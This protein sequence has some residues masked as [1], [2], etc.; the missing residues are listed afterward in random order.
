MALKGHGSDEM[1]AVQ[2]F[3]QVFQLAAFVA[4]VATTLGISPPQF[5][6]SA[7]EPAQPPPVSEGDTT[8]LV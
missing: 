6:K 1:G 7:A 8:A 2:G 5:G 3:L 4:V